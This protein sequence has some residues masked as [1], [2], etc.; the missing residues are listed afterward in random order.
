[1]K[2]VLM[3]IRELD[4]LMLEQRKLPQEADW[5]QYQWWLLQTCR[6]HSKWFEQSSNKYLWAFLSR[7]LLSGFTSLQD[8][9]VRNIFAVVFP[10]FLSK[11]V[12]KESRAKTKKIDLKLP[13]FV[14]RID[15]LSRILRC[16]TKGGGDVA[17]CQCHSLAMS[18]S[19]LAN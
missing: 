17:S 7:N 14:S 2:F 11:D 9:N 15:L 5:Q 1:M 16:I 3:N 19:N 18:L 10:V 6:L 13:G 12:L 8:L 4:I